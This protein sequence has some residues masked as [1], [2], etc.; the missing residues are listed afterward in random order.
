MSVTVSNAAQFATLADNTTYTFTSNITLTAP[1]TLAAG[2]TGNNITVN[3]A[4]RT[5]IVNSQAWNGLFS[6]NGV[7]VSDLKVDGTSATPNERAGWVFAAN[8]S[9]NA[10][11]C[12]S[13][14]AIGSGGGGIFGASSSGTATNC[15]STGAIGGDGGGIFGF[16]SAGTATNCYS[17]GAITGGGGIFGSNSTGTAINCYSTGAIVG[18]GIFGVNSSG[19]ATNC[20]S[21]GAIGYIESF[22]DLV[23]TSVGGGIFGYR[24]S[25]TAINCYSTGVIV[26]GAGITTGADESLVV[27]VANCYF[28]GGAQ[29]SDTDAGENLNNTQSV[30]YNPSGN[31]PWL[32][33]SF[34]SPPVITV[35]N[36][37]SSSLNLSWI[38]V[39]TS[40]GVPLTGYTVKINGATYDVSGN[41]KAITGLTAGTTYPFF[42]AGKN[43]QR[44]AP[45]TTGSVTTLAA[46]APAA[47]TVTATKVT[48]TSLTLGWTVAANGSPITRY[49]VT[50]GGKTVQVT[51]NKLDI[52]GLKANTLT[53]FSVTAK[54]AIGTG[55]AGSLKV[56]P[57]GVPTGFSANKVASTFLTLDWNAPAIN[58]S[59]IKKYTVAVAPAGPIIKVTG[60]GAVVTKMKA[61]TNYTFTVTATNSSG[62]G[63]PATL[64]QATPKIVHAYQLFFIVR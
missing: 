52:K 29:W 61:K 58:G 41:S 37:T 18:G 7:S 48:A 47:P 9:G 8:K 34:I 2:S 49:N 23:V 38:P 12:S 53:T 28:T 5:V 10:I 30:W 57:P 36:I 14:G 39:N 63:K 64:K 62:T 44:T 43:A 50:Y 27:T 1:P 56:G 60:T 26:A 3:G 55:P 17:T 59:A 25:G 40:Y 54:N 22:G 20:Y 45:G 32:L 19:T 21:T 16:Q 15:S 13:T 46:T 4:G 33:M 24:S 11:N 6:M 31:S 51:T 42:V 35:S